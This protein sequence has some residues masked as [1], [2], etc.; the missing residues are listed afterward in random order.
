[1]TSQTGRQGKKS[2]RISN[3]TSGT[4]VGTTGSGAHEASSHFNIS[5][6]QALKAVLSRNLANVEENRGSVDN[7]A[8]VR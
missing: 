4:V 2:E 7:Q 5:N 6:L 1:M 3:T 8:Q